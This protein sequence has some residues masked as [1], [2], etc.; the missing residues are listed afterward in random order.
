MPPEP[1]L[2]HELC[3][4]VQHHVD[5]DAWR[6]VLLPGSEE[7]G[8]DG[9]RASLQEA[10]ALG[11]SWG[12]T[13]TLLRDAAA[14]G[15]P[16]EPAPQWSD[17]AMAEVYDPSVA[18][19]AFSHE[20]LRWQLI[21]TSDLP[22]TRHGPIVR[23]LGAEVWQDGFVALD[24]V[25]SDGTESS[26]LTE[27]AEAMA[28]PDPVPEPWPVGIGAPQ[29]EVLSYGTGPAGETLAVLASHDIALDAQGPGR[30]IAV[31]IT[32]SDVAVIVSGCEVE[33][34]AFLDT[35]AGLYRSSPRMGILSTGSCSAR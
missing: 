2:V 15:C 27:V 7:L 35:A 23:V 19:L 32:E 9:E 12:P 6:D 20:A 11:C 18:A 14:A 34:W 26:I 33:R 4:G 3:H 25:K 13:G 22:E 5:V 17:V 29:W 21:R 24:V 8:R 30:T 31:S 28:P 1:T 16:S 10:F